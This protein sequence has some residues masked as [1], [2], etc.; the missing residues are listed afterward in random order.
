[1]IIPS[2]K[3]HLDNVFLCSLIMILYIYDNDFYLFL[4]MIVYI[5]DN[6]FISVLIMIHDK[7]SRMWLRFFCM[8]DYVNM[9][10]W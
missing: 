6:D 2:T 9:Y 10:P 3:Q 7:L 8:Y 1:M 5:Y 4:T